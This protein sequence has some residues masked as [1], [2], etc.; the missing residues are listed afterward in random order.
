MALLPGAVCTHPWKHPRLGWV[1]TRQAELG[2]QPAR[3]MG[4]AGGALRSLSTQA[5]L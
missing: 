5:M 4:V 1:G 3:G 2:G